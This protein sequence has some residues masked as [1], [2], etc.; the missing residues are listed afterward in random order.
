MYNVHCTYGNVGNKKTVGTVL[1]GLWALEW[2]RFD[3]FRD[4]SVHMNVFLNL[5]AVC[6]C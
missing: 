3:S 4:I 1:S 5:W 6:G 2:E